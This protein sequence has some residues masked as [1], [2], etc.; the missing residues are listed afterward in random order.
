[1]LPEIKQEDIHSTIDKG[2]YD[3]GPNGRFWTLDPIDGTK[4]FL[5][6]EQYAVA[7]ALIEDGEV[8]LGILGCPNLTK[9]LKNP[10][11]A[12]GLIFSAVKGQGASAQHIKWK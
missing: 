6:G 10:D 4:G 12:Q 11:G 8:V 7:L 9:D 5:R 3:G 1:M 2:S